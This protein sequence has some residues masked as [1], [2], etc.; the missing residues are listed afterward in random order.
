MNQNT[1]LKYAFIFAIVCKVVS[2]VASLFIFTWGLGFTLPLLVMFAYVVYGFGATKSLNRSVVL[3][4]GDSCYYL[5]FLFTVA[6]LSIALIDIGHKGEL[7]V[8]DVAIRFG[9]AMITTLV[10]MAIRVWLVTFA[11]GNDKIKRPKAGAITSGTKPES[12][13]EELGDNPTSSNR[14]VSVGEGNKTRKE[15]PTSSGIHPKIN[16][17]DE[18]KNVV[19]SDTNSI[20]KTDKPLLPEGVFVS[21]EDGTEYIINVSLDNLRNLNNALAENVNY[22]RRLRENLELL[23]GRVSNDLIEATNKVAEH[24]DALMKLTEDSIQKSHEEYQK[25]LEKEF[26]FIQQRM[27]ELMNNNAEQSNALMKLT[28]E[29]VNKSH[30]AHQKLLDEL[31]K[32]N[33]EHTK[34]I[35]DE[36]MDLVSN[37]AKSTLADLKD[38][39]KSISENLNSEIQLRIQDT[40]SIARTSIA[41]INAL[42]KDATNEIAMTGEQIA[43]D[44]SRSMSNTS[45]QLKAISNRMEQDR[46]RFVSSSKAITD[47]LN[48]ATLQIIKNV[49]DTCQS[50]SKIVQHTEGT[51][52]HQVSGIDDGLNRIDGSL[53]S[54]SRNAENLNREVKQ[55]AEQLNRSVESLSTEVE[56]FEEKMKEL[57]PQK[58]KRFFGLF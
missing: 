32:N 3:K 46:D 12:G 24:G 30:E 41:K 37:A 10:G 58:R 40:D 1:N 54:I 56:N 19:P 18:G 4:Y 31:I 47:N 23:C 21:D 51:L 13:D 34:Q 38:A 44:V 8:A 50:F 26:E 53:N 14:P 52:K 11:D 35:A 33:A 49:D 20:P 43:G 27:N 2:A 25:H 42:T 39:L 28:E 29:T 15:E 57:Q 22:S 17:T 36:T 55:T 48:N 7:T 9:A 16:K 45:D 6:S 5:G